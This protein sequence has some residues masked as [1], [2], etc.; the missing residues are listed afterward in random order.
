MVASVSGVQFAIQ[1]RAQPF[2]GNEY[3]L[4]FACLTPRPFPAYYLAIEASIVSEASAAVTSLKVRNTGDRFF[5]RR[6]LE[7]EPFT[8]EMGGSKQAVRLS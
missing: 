1:K 5:H 4:Q 2:K 6:K 3:E 7:L 8:P